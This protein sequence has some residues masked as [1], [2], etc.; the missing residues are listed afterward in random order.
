MNN[1][2]VI[3]IGAGPIGLTC[4]IEA[5]KRNISSLIIEKGCLV[6]SLFHYPTNMT[7]FS[8]SERLEIGEV[9]FVSHGD[10]PTRRESLEYY[11]RTAETWALNINTYEEVSNIEKSGDIFRLTTSKEEYTARNIIVS[12]GFFDK[13]N[14]L[15]IPGEEKQKVKHYFDEAHPY[16]Y[17]KL[18]VIGGA[19]SAVDVALETYRR[20]SE[21]S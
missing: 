16:A 8:T 21:V 19:N 9:P 18:I 4:A 1:F 14:L 5:K 15:N 2:D 20:G 7:F 10:K 13:P 17:L 3:I 6:N 11:R 12:T